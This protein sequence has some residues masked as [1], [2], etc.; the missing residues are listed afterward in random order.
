MTSIE[1]RLNRSQRRGIG[2]THI[3]VFLDKRIIDI[4]HDSRLHLTIPALGRVASARTPPSSHGCRPPGRSLK[5]AHLPGITRITFKSLETITR[6]SLPVNV[7][8]SPFAS[9]KKGMT[10]TVYPALSRLTVKS[11]R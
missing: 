2:M 3:A 6:T 1:R 11:A 7:H 9:S 10:P 5:T 4:L 8:L